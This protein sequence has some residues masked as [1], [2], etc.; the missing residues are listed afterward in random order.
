VSSAYG[1]PKEFFDT[2]T[3]QSLRNSRMTRSSLAIN[4]IAIFVAL[5]GACDD[6]TNLARSCALGSD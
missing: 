2:L 5:L 1:V 6:M 4:S 3:G